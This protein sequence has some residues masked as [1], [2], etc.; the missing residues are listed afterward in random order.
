MILTPRPASAADECDPA[1]GTPPTVTCDAAE[2]RG[3][4]QTSKLNGILY[5]V[6]SNTQGLI[7]T[8]EEDAHVSGP[9][10]NGLRV[11]A[12]GNVVLTDNG[13]IEITSSGDYSVYSSGILV[14]IGDGSTS[15]STVPVTLNIP[16]GVFRMR[17]QQDLY[18]G[19]VKLDST[20]NQSD[21]E[22][23]FNGQVQ[24]AHAKS[25]GVEVYEK[26]KAGGS[27]SVTLQSGARIGG[28]VGYGVKIHN[29]DAAEGVEYD[30]VVSLN[31]EAG[32][33]IGSQAQPVKEDGVF[34]RL[35]IPGQRLAT[36]ST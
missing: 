17:H 30:K 31:I 25:I 4:V 29:E 14:D 35:T 8:V 7:L 3:I 6:R 23:N 26:E 13:K 22:V 27:I 19:A 32:A 2:T 36:M 20:N 15:Q 1:T 18:G 16:K 21:L 28:N 11:T 33:G 12:A 5:N 24:G 9:F 10:T 34:V